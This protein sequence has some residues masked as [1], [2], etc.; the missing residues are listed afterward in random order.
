MPIECKK[1]VEDC[2]Y[3]NGEKCNK[4]GAGCIDGVKNCA[5]DISERHEDPDWIEIP[6][7]LRRGND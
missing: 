4:C 5:H 2:D 6:K 1:S 7:F 3:C